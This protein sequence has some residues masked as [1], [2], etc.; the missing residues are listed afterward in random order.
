MI[1]D[2]TAFDAEEDDVRAV[3]EIA[4][5]EP[6]SEAAVAVPSSPSL[7]ST[8]TGCARETADSD[9]DGIFEDSS[10]PLIVDNEVWRP[11]VS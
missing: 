11:I 6:A 2:D 4:V 1:R 9:A 5:F 7:K 8:H 10:A 3:A